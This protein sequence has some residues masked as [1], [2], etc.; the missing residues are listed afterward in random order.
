MNSKKGPIILDNRD[1]REKCKEQGEINELLE[2]ESVE[3][4][5]VDGVV[6]DKDYVEW[7]NCPVCKSK[8][9]RQLFLKRGFM[10]VACRN[11]THVFVRNVLRKEYIEGLY[12]DSSADNK[13]LE[14]QRNPYHLKY[15]NSIYEKY[16]EIVTELSGKNC[17]LLDLGCGI[18]NFLRFVSNHQMGKKYILHGLEL[19]AKASSLIEQ[20]VKVEN[21]YKDGIEQIEIKNKFGQ[22]YLWGV[23]EHLSNPMNV[24]RKCCEI[25]DDDGVI[26]ALVPNFNSLAIKILGVNTPTFEPRSHIQFFTEESI[27]YMC[28]ELGFYEVDVYFELPVIDL[29]YKYLHY[30]ERLAQTIIDDGEGYYRIQILK[31]K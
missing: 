25:L 26:L 7:I 28:K 6:L 24:L 13:N 18:G 20:H 12:V 23:L 19:N 4:P 31:K 22:I 14:L 2:T 16:F 11:C 30:S 17:N 29:M 21:L 15:W 27:Q 3:L 5:K 9:Y 10:Y 8:L 1:W